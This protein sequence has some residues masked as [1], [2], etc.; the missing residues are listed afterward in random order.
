[1]LWPL[2]VPTFSPCRCLLTLKTDTV[3]APRW[4]GETEGT[5][6]SLLRKWPHKSDRETHL[7]LPVKVLLLITSD[8]RQAEGGGWRQSQG[9]G[10]GVGSLCIREAGADT[11]GSAA[12]A[13]YRALDSHCLG[14]CRGGFP[15]FSPSCEMGSFIH[16]LYLADH[17][18]LL[19]SHV[20]P[21]HPSFHGTGLV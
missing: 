6:I 4:P 20:I 10:A 14:L 18:S 2:E 13:P 17:H 9:L 19:L 16:F 7:W 3:A 1:M 12:P 5:L 21:Y 15:D 11:W 8:V